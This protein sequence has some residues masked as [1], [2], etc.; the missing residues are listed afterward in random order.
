MSFNKLY[1]K[2]LVESQQLGSDGK[3]VLACVIYLFICHS[4]HFP[5]YENAASTLLK[6]QDAALDN[7]V[8][9]RGALKTSIRNRINSMPDTRWKESKCL[10]RQA[11][12]QCSLTPSWTRTSIRCNAAR[13]GSSS[14]RSVLQGR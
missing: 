10:P 1:E 8:S 2:M 14:K 6:Q 13:G 7:P 4:N 3:R 5:N 9:R 11:E 12:S